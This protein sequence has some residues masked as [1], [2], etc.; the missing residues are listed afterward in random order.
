MRNRIPA[1]VLCVLAVLLI[2]PTQV[3]ALEVPSAVTAPEARG[4]VENQ[5]LDE[6][7][8]PGMRLPAEAA[9]QTENTF[10]VI[11][12]S[13]GFLYY[14]MFR[15]N[16]DAAGYGYFSFKMR[17]IPG[18]EASQ[19]ASDIWPC[20]WLLDVLVDPIVR[21]DTGTPYVLI[22]LGGNDLV[23]DYPDIGDAVFPRI[24]SDLREIV[25][26]L[27]SVNSNVKIILAGYDIG[28]IE[29]SQYCIDWAI[30]KFGTA[31]PELLNPILI[32]L[33]EV[34][35][36]VAADY[37]QVYSSFVW[38][39]LQGNPGNP[40]IYSWSPLQYFTHYPFWDEDCIH[41]NSLGYDVFTDAVID[42]MINNG[43]LQ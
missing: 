36:A 31:E 16:M 39:A 4:R 21:N 5:L 15:G 9:G 23:N 34:N 18:T 26:E 28:N 27:I 8:G 35:D 41:L 30:D 12:D 43:V 10:T 20:T 2:A 32:R 1:V 19:W 22:S 11:G 25:E 7:L 14:P 3:L 42:W 13:W 37:E 38:G 29:K 40:D 24:D 33:G 6:C 17:A